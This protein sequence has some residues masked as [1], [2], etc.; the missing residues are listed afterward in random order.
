MADLS[1][2]LEKEQI[3]WPFEL[4]PI[5]LVP[6]DDQM[7][8][9]WKVGCFTE[10][11]IKNM[12]T[13]LRRRKRQLEHYENHLEKLIQQSNTQAGYQYDEMNVLDVD[14]EIAQMDILITK[15]RQR[16][17][18]VTV[19]RWLWL[20]YNYLIEN[21]LTKLNSKYNN[22]H[23]SDSETESGHKNS[24][25]KKRKGKS[26]QMIIC[27]A[28]LVLNPFVIRNN[29]CINDKHLSNTLD[30]QV[31]SFIK[32]FER[33]KETL[34]NYW[35]DISK[36]EGAIE[37][38]CIDKIMR[39]RE[40]FINTPTVLYMTKEMINGSVLD[41]LKYLPNKNNI[42]QLEDSLL[43][44]NLKQQISLLNY[45]EQNGIAHNNIKPSNVLISQDGRNLL[46]TDFCPQTLF[47]ER[48]FKVRNG[49]LNSAKF[50]SPEF[51]L[52][53]TN[54]I[55]FHNVEE[56]NKLSEEIANKVDRYDF[57]DKVKHF[58]HKNDVFCLGLIYYFLL[59]LKIPSEEDLVYE[60]VISELKEML[61]TRDHGNSLI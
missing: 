30:S 3:E 41:Y 55:P 47:V 7:G 4:R 61:K 28:K 43:F 13:E 15:L 44:N 49:K 39:K 48:C 17:Q 5:H 24:I 18:D 58:V 9:C 23:E 38:M 14:G 8:D 25:K 10:Q 31:D 34:E 32:E 60:E 19:A 22:D 6:G 33:I 52:L 57:P 46:L 2:L 35:I 42:Y 59:T 36:K 1:S 21:E 37:I 26:E 27:Y 40:P 12:E 11:L 53:L 54:E 29:N 56:S 50:I 20:C 16:I 51:T 45:M